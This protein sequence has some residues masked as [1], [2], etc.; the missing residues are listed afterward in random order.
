MSDP[1]DNPTQD[2]PL[3]TSLARLEEIAKALEKG[4]LPLEDGLKL[5][6]EGVALARRLEGRLADAEMKV[7]TLLRG[8]SG[9][10]RVVPYQGPGGASAGPG[11]AEEQK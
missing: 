5:F 2:T 1:I 7:E 9:D 11:G 3:E 10:E 6:E 4:D 8:A